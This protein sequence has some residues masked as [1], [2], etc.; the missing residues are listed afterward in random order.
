VEKDKKCVFR[1]GGQW[2]FEGASTQVSFSRSSPSVM[3]TVQADGR[4]FVYTAEQFKDDKFPK[5]ELTHDFKMKPVEFTISSVK[6][7]RKLL[8]AN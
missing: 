5:D 7:L 4:L 8:N 3:I 2:S 1:Y 6:D